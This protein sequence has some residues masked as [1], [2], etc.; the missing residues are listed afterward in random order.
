MQSKGRRCLHRLVFEDFN[1]YK[2]NRTGAIVL[3]R[4][5]VIAHPENILLTGDFVIAYTKHILLT[6]NFFIA[7]TKN[8]PS[9]K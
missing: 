8:L 6:E 1:I 5:F 2:V 9:Q 3:N 7:Y 4:D